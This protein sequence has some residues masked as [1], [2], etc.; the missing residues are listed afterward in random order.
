MSGPSLRPGVGAAAFGAAIAACTLLLA[1]CGHSGNSDNVK[2]L[3][4]PNI[5]IAVTIP[6]GWHRVIDSNDLDIPEMV[7]PITCSGDGEVNCATGLARLATF[8]APTAAAAAQTVQRAVTT[9]PGVHL[10][11]TTK[12]GPGTI[13]HR[14]G[15]RLRFSFSNPAAELVSEVAAV[16]TGS[17]SPDAQ[18]NHK[19]SVVL[20]WVSDAPGAPKPDV[21]DRI[22]GSVLVVG[23]QS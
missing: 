11:E 5:D 7:S 8:A 13:D 22:V 20:V 17:A 4:G 2:H 10:G 14:N 9:S 16:P 1:G 23:H 18:G 15:Y 19:F 12:E 6:T 21:I 3:S